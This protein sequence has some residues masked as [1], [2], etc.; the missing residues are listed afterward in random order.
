MEHRKHRVDDAAFA[1]RDRGNPCS[2]L[3]RVCEKVPVREAG[4][5]R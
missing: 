2:G 3:R 1:A 4:A 5:L